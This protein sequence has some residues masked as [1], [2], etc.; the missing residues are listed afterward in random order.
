MPDTGKADPL[1]TRLE[2]IDTAC[3]GVFEAAISNNSDA[4]IPH[5]LTLLKCGLTALTEIADAQQ[6]MAALAE[7]DITAE[8]NS[9]VEDAS[10][11]KAV[12]LVEEQAKRNFIGNKG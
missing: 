3:R 1:A 11:A 8:I 12:E 10:I 9:A 4:A 7:I 6:R 2:H 5:A